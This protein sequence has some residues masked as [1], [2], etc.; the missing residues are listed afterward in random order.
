MNK[1]E[2][3]EKIAKGADISKEKAKKA[4]DA[5]IETITSSLKKKEPVSLPGFGSFDVSKRKAREGRNP[6]TGEKIKI[7]A[8]KVP[9]FKAGKGLKDAVK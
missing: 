9:K 4:L 1:S 8:T 5:T 6:A 2:L 7:P 3:V